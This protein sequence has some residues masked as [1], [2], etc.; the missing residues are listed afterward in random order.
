MYLSELSKELYASCDIGI[1]DVL[2]DHGTDGGW[3][4]TKDIDPDDF[5]LLD[6]IRWVGNFK[7]DH[8]AFRP[9]HCVSLVDEGLDWFF[10]LPLRHLFRHMLR[11]HRDLI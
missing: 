7:I 4:C 3:T 8:I 1:I 5:C 9:A 6:D 2:V 11:Q 10:E